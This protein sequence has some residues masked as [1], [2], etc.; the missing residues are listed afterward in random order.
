MK[1]S[2]L[3][4]IVFL[5]AKSSLVFS[6]TNVLLLFRRLPEE[7]VIEL[8]G[9]INLNYVE[10]GI[11]TGT[12]VIFLHG[13]TDSWHS[14]D[15]VLSNL[16]KNM[17]AFAITQRGHGNSDKPASGYSPKDFAND[18]AA[19]IEKRKLGPVVVVG[20]SM[21][22]VVV[23]RF[24]MDHPELTKAVVIIG[25]ATSVKNFSSVK[26]FVEMVNQLNDPIEPAFAEEFQK[27]T[28]AKPINDSYYKE[29]VGESLKVPARVWKGILN[30]LMNY[31]PSGELNIIRK[32]TLIVWGEQDIF[33]Q[34][35]SQDNLLKSIKNSRLLIYKGTGHAVHWEEPQRFS[36]DLVIFI[37][38][39]GKAK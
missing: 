8:P 14:F 2:Q 3:L 35:E 21:G 13:Y 12:P 30:D 29:L 39:L 28:L 38:N 34:R 10:Q 1:K 19:F 31:D 7:K 32:P 37:N 22:G 27:S 16:P 6:Q 33:C 17:H 25:S 9:N 36:N 15:S 5:I 26:E 24:A 20:H 18:V 23:Q 11:S 4:L